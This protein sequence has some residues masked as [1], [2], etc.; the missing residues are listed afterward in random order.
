METVDSS[1]RQE[2]TPLTASAQAPPRIRIHSASICV[3][4]QLVPPSC[5][6]PRGSSAS[7]WSSVGSSAHCHLVFFT[8]EDAISALF[9]VENYQY[10]V[11]NLATVSLR[12]CIGENNLEELFAHR[13]Q[14]NKRLKTLLDEKT[15][16][17]GIRVDSVDI[18]DLTIPANLQRAMA[19]IAE[20]TR[21]AE[22]KVIA[23]NGQ[24]RAASVLLEAA[25]TMAR[26]PMSL[27]L[28]W[29]EVL[30]ELGVND[31]MTTIVVPD[32]VRNFAIAP[33]S[34]S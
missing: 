10:A 34:G 6:S 14:I 15:R 24:L 21:A 3:T 2:L 20:S 1:Q 23:A 33:P 17:W 30:R 19:A 18:R 5:G 28:Q 27:Q 16:L 29:F 7:C 12:T 8:V 26:E 4:A 11:Q 31:K 22:S 32:N 25:Q 9:E 13:A